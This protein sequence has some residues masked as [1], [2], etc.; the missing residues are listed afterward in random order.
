MT[1]ICIYGKDVQGSGKLFESALRKVHIGLMF[2]HVVLFS[3]CFWGSSYYAMA[4]NL[5]V[6]IL[7][8][9]VQLMLKHWGLADFK[10]LV[11]NFKR[12]K[13]E[14]PGVNDKADWV[15][16]YTHPFV[17]STPYI[18][19][20][21]MKFNMPS[22][23][24]EPHQLRNP[25]EERRKKFELDLK[26][27][28]ELTPKL[29]LG[30]RNTKSM[31][32]ER[33]GSDLQQVFDPTDQ[34]LFRI[35]EPRNIAIDDSSNL[36]I[37]DPLVRQHEEAEAAAL[38]QKTTI[39]LRTRQSMR[40]PKAHTEDKTKFSEINIFSTKKDSQHIYMNHY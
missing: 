9:Y 2:T 1:F 13:F 23:V 32:M 5:L 20:Y 4:V 38:D 12:I 18:K 34:N 11:H 3:Q 19:E 40:S 29:I 22:L 37:P 10:N 39:R 16:A 26:K 15:Y 30:I 21:I 17:K 36:S 28:P 33:P 7:C 25:D 8:L 31:V 14:T 6:A 35:P 24:A 27:L